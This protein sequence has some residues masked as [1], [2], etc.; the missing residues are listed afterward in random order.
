MEADALDDDD[1]V[2]SGNSGRVV[3]GDA[4][5]VVWIGSA[6]VVTERPLCNFS[7]HNE[8]NTPHLQSG[9]L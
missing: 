8:G 2:M 6:A 9:P 4:S 3:D 7:L 5:K 1:D